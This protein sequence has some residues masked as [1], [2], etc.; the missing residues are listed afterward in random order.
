MKYGDQLKNTNS[1]ES[2]NEL[3]HVNM[4]RKLASMYVTDTNSSNEEILKF[5]SRQ[6]VSDSEMKTILSAMRNSGNIANQDVSNTK[7]LS[8]IGDLLDNSKLSNKN[9][10]VIFTDFLVDIKRM[11]KDNL[12][13]SEQMMI[14]SSLKSGNKDDIKST[15]VKINQSLSSQVKENKIQERKEK[16]SSTD[17]VS[18]RLNSDV[19]SKVLE[20]S[21]KTIEDI[22][23]ERASEVSEGRIAGSISK[24][25]D[26]IGLSG[27]TDFID[28]I[29]DVSGFKDAKNKFISKL[30]QTSV[31]LTEKL[32]PK[33]F[34]NAESLKEKKEEIIDNVESIIQGSQTELYKA[35]EDISNN[36]SNLEQQRERGE[37]SDKK[38]SELKNNLEE[39]L[40]NEQLKF[41]KVKNKYEDQLASYKLELQEQE[42]LENR[43]NARK[44]LD[45][46]VVGNKEFL[47]SQLDADELSLEDYNQMTSSDNKLKS[48]ILNSDK[49][50][51]LS[52]SNK[53]EYYDSLKRLFSE[54]VEQ[55]Y[56]SDT[57]IVKDLEPVLDAI[58]DTNVEPIKKEEYVSLVDSPSPS[59][60]LSSISS[61]EDVLKLL[62]NIDLNT[63]SM[64]VKLDSFISELN[65]LTRMNQLD[66]NTD[67]IVK[68]AGS[69]NSDNLSEDSSSSSESD[70]SAIDTLANLIVGGL[71]VGTGTLGL[72]MFSDD[73]KVAE[74]SRDTGSD[75]GSAS[76]ATIAT[77]KA[78]KTKSLTTNSKP[79][80]KP[81]KPDNMVKSIVKGGVK[82]ATKSIPVIG[83]ALGALSIGSTL[84]DDKLSGLDK[85]DIVTEEVGGMVGAGLGAAKGAALGA[86][87]GP[88][89]MIAGGLIGGILGHFAGSTIGDKGGDLVFGNHNKAKEKSAVAL[90]N[91]ES[92][93]VDLNSIQNSVK[94]ISKTGSQRS[95]SRTP[96]KNIQSPSGS[97]SSLVN[98]VTIDDLGIVL[99]NSGVT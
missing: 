73:S 89:G 11:F 66:K 67:S 77:A 51:S 86:V 23:T 93:N 16:L 39:K 20:G 48:E 61:S 25:E 80:K 27:S 21:T 12:S 62:N 47:K 18:E 6:A 33:R 78:I 7:F 10:K 90:S 68:Q 44:L 88:I 83:T 96:T 54:S 22:A 59:N 81:K 52:Y 56:T 57:T 19:L 58:G 75:I 85:G 2:E 99:I 84:A 37:I 74:K 71:I 42:S 3:T 1:K 34:Q 91:P 98:P 24:F 72:S 65:N 92:S 70:G 82:G 79:P 4:A 69:L 50:K 17:R 53:D 32:L 60:E 97:S 63:K 55:E 38:F 64:E 36:I 95:R 45:E 5:L 40:L 49:F 8:N 13:E 35:Q 46:M 14:D 31:N 29:L 30:G 94:N 9:Q 26:A 43:I 87:L 76:A 15:L 28:K 41:E